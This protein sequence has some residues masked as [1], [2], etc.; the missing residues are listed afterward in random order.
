MGLRIL[1]PAYPRIRDVGIPTSL[2]TRF[3]ANQDVIKNKIESCNLGYLHA[4]HSSLLKSNTVPF[5]LTCAICRLSMIR[6]LLQPTGFTLRPRR[7]YHR[8]HR[9]PGS[10]LP[11]SASSACSWS[12]PSW[13]FPLMSFASWNHQIHHPLRLHAF[14]SLTCQQPYHQQPCHQ[15]CCQPCH[16]PCPFLFRP[17]LFRLHLA[18]RCCHCHHCHHCYQ[19]EGAC[20][21]WD[22][23][24]ELW[25]GSASNDITTIHAWPVFGMIELSASSK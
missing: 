23:H 22:C 13:S 10:G 24:Q 17:F 14:C 6:L 3:D 19:E 12:L 15:P 2:L 8:H 7:P 18:E 5:S 21:H 9:R 11:G 20:S 4:F 16:R 1:Q 25:G